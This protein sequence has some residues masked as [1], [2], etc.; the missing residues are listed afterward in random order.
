MGLEMYP[1][2]IKIGSTTAGADGDVAFIYLTGNCYITMNGLGCFYP[3]RTPRSRLG[4]IP[5][6]EVHPTIAGIKAGR[7]ELMEFALNCALLNVH[8]DYCTSV[9]NATTEWISTVTLGTN[10]K[11]S[12]S[13]ATIGYEN[14]SSTEFA[15]EA[16]KT[17]PISLLPG[18]TNSTYENWAV[19]IDYNGDKGFD[20]PGE[21]VFSKSRSD[22]VVSGT[23][24]IPAGLSITTRMRVSMSSSMVPGRCSML[25][26][27][28]VEDYTLII[29]SLN[30]VDIPSDLSSQVVIWPN[31]VS[32]QLNIQV[33]EFSDQTELAIF[34]LDGK[35]IHKDRLT[36]NL[37]TIDV[38]KWDCGIYLVRLTCGGYV[39]NQ[40]FVK[41]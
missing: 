32:R 33:G 31:P 10:S 36:A 2:A 30:H 16:G 27:G 23:I 24:V 4:I 20:E 17:Y 7:D 15:I 6:Y 38:S 40:K 13:S 3:D 29:N 12:G 41:D 37:S 34:S 5:D 9:G 1:D 39:L 35:Q 25:P 8:P 28:E 14:F 21:L 19:W 26:A 22:T 18:F 11:T